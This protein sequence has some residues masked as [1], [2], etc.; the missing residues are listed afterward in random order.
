[1]DVCTTRILQLED[2]IESLGV[3]V[4][5]PTPDHA[6]LLADV[7]AHSGPGKVREESKEDR[8]S[9]KACEGALFAAEPSPEVFASHDPCFTPSINRH[10]QTSTRFELEQ[11]PDA[12]KPTLLQIHDL[13]F[14][15]PYLPDFSDSI[16]DAFDLMWDQ[17]QDDLFLQDAGILD[18]SVAATVSDFSQTAHDSQSRDTDGQAFNSTDD[19]SDDEIIEQLSSRMGDLYL[20]PEGNLKYLGATSNMTLAQRWTTQA[21][22]A[23]IRPTQTRAKPTAPDLSEDLYSHLTALFFAWQNAFLNIVEE[24][25]Y[26]LAHDHCT[27]GKH[28]VFYSEALKF[29]M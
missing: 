24:N 10:Q 16:P 20:D 11:A 14:Q 15:V 17:T 18:T 4:P 21:L 12:Q 9:G 6:S 7:V 2:A 27:T 23:P 3:V 25:T 22:A 1:M 8:C 13:N 26:V 29:A 28:N 19:D 5:S